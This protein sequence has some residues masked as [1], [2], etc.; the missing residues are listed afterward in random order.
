MS[1]SSKYFFVLFACVVSLTNCY[2]SK[3]PQRAEIKKLQ[4]GI[5]KDDS[6]FVYQLPYEAGESHLLVQGY[7]SRYSH[8]NR[9]ALDFKMK[10]GTKICAVRTGVVI[11][12]KEDGDRGGWNRKYRSSGNMIVIQHEDSSRAGYWHLQL[13]GALVNVGDTVQQGQV[14]GLSGK[15]GYTLF[16]HLHFISWK[17]SRGQWGPVAT[18]F[19]TDKGILYL[20]PFR[21]YRNSY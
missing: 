17:S 11:R 9:A 8:R 6:S 1:A 14:I 19:Q 16:P 12:V 2:V 4:K 10:R 15:T 20:R 13:N 18:R 7:F 21:N 3:D 5:I